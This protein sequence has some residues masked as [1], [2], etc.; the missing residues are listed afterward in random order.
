M[1]N[2]PNTNVRLAALDGLAKFYRDDYV[3]KQLIR[4]LKKQRDPMV[5]ISLI[6][7]L[8]RM[9]ESAILSQLEGMAKDDNNIDAVKQTAYSGILELRG[10]WV[11]NYAIT[12][13][14][15]V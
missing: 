6:G 15:E 2:D 10:S 7:L 4:S 13:Q 14:I 1:N 8:T 3:K 12:K 9:K 5:Q 11:N